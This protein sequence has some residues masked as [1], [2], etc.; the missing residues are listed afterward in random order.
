MRFEQ[1]KPS[2]EEIK[3]AEK[4]M[5]INQDLASLLRHNK[6]EFEEHVQEW[7]V[8]RNENGSTD[9]SGIIDGT[10]I[11]LHGERY[12]GG[13]TI[14]TYWSGKVGVGG[15]M[16]EI[17][18][19]DA[20]HLFDKYNTNSEAAE[21]LPEYEAKAKKDIEEMKSANEIVDKLLGR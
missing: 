9:V 5:T 2:Q 15:R 18:E 20:M 8:T 19:N 14:G 11:Q 1:Y 7:K 10:K 3:K 21:E 4:A 17:S 6:K 12:K 16:V 13:N